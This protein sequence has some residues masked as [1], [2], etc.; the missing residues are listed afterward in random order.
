MVITI[1]GP[2]GTGKSSVAHTVAKRLGFDF[3]DTGAM[4]R[5][6]GLEALRREANLEDPRELTFIAR[7]A[8]ISFDYAKHP[9]GV[10]LN[11]EPV[12]HL[13]RSGEA[14]RAASYVAQVP[15][16]REM[17]VAQQRQIGQDRQNLVTEGRD[18]GSVVFPDAE[19]KV[20]LDASPAERARR[21]AGQLRA[22]GEI[23]DSNEILGQIVARDQR[24]KSRSV[25]PLAVPAGATVIDTTTLSQDQVVDRIVE[26][27]RERQQQSAGA[28]AEGRAAV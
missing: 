27:V 12:G 13:V 9:P 18:Q 10:L 26:A 5:A 14:T 16:I 8:R 22:R 21:R 19:L 17:L 15:A 1:D 2:A 4:Y 20:Y 23:V 6:I 3:L 25:G 7:H 24:D 28:A 11:G